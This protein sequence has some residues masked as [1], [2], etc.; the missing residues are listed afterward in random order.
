VHSVAAYL[1]A[2]SLFYFC[3]TLILWSFDEGDYWHRT[4][5]G[6][7]AHRTSPWEIITFSFVAALFAAMAQ[8]LANFFLFL[9][10]L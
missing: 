5:R 1:V 9:M 8:A 7:R 10:T 2:F 3:L 6:M 4:L